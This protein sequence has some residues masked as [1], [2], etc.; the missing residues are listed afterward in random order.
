MINYAKPQSWSMESLKDGIKNNADQTKWFALRHT[1][2][3]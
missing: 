2:D 1:N 3:K